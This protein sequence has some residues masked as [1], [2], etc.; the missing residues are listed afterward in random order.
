MS[1]YIPPEFTITDEN[2]IYDFMQSN[3][4]ATLLS[5]DNENDEIYNTAIPF[6]ISKD[7]K[8]NKIILTG[9]M[10]RKNPHINHI[11]SSETKEKKK[12]MTVL[13]QG[14]HCY[15]SPSFYNL[16]KNPLN[17]P[18]WNYMV[19]KA[20]GYIQKYELDDV[21]M[22]IMLSK[23]VENNEKYFK[24][25]NKVWELNS[26]TPLYRKMMFQSIIGFKIEIDTV[27]CKFK[28]SQNKNKEE[29]GNVIKGLKERETYLDNSMSLSISNNMIKYSPKSNL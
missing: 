22:D 25:N 10:A 14:S 2:I 6:L 23:I 17:V 28:L 4:F 21:E 15:I 18:T 3:A 1:Q 26:T 20:S 24:D 19:V 13:F 8:T 16:N 11:I 29:Y 5:Y 27:L 7:N 9:H 12:K